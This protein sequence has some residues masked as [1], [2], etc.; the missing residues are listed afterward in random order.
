[1]LTPLCSYATHKS[2]I[3]VYGFY[4]V[5]QQGGIVI[6]LLK[7]DYIV[8]CCA[9]LLG[10]DLLDLVSMYSSRIKYV[11]LTQNKLHNGEHVAQCNSVAHLCMEIF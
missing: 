1:M 6:E 9:L 11:G 8:H 2:L 7:Q 4:F 5:T 10:E 3:V